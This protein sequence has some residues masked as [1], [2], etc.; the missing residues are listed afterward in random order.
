MGLGLRAAQS[1][2]QLM[3]LSF[4]SDTIVTSLCT[5]TVL[6]QGLKTILFPS[7][8]P[9]SRDGLAFPFVQAENGGTEKI[10]DSLSVIQESWARTKN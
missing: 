6:S 1:P 10:N 2:H 8:L 9:L 3:S 7:T 5:L 4:D